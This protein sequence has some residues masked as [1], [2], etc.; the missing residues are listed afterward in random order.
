MLNVK[1]GSFW[2]ANKKNLGTRKFEITLG[3]PMD[4]KRKVK[5]GKNRRDWIDVILETERKIN[6][7]FFLVATRKRS[8][9]LTLIR[10]G[11]E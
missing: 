8:R 5:K 6:L 3:I 1:Y 9:V 7:H 4:E 10:N 11:T 2:I